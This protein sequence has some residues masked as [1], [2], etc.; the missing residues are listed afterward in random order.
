[1]VLH[2]FTTK[3]IEDFHRI[4]EVLNEVLSGLEIS[5]EHVGSTAIM[6]L[7]AKPIIDI[8]TKIK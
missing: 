1:M 2:A 4:K 8:V 7:A 5:I 6:G 3:W